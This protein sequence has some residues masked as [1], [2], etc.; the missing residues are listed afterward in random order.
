MSSVENNQIVIVT[1]L[2]RSGTSMMMKML[3]AGGVCPLCD[4]QR[5]ADSDNPNGYYEFEP[6][7]QTRHDASWLNAAAGKAVKMV[8]SLLYDLPTDRHYDVIFMRRDLTEILASQN[9]MLHNMDI[10][11]AVDDQRMAGLFEREINRFQQ[12]LAKVSHVNSIE[13][14]YNDVASGCATPINSINEQ[15]GGRLDVSAMLSVV[16]PALYRNRSAAS[17]AA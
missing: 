10:A 13:V 12:W 15:L 3:E 9:R 1:G 6:V 11:S 14:P 7:K 8:Y 16:D 4:G 5:T 17:A 2:P